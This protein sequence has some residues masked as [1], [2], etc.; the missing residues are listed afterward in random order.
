MKRTLKDFVLDMLNSIDEVE[1]FSSGLS[2][3]QFGKDP[4]DNQR[5]NPI[6]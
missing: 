2:F 6:T 4:E 5:G 3:E 1:Q